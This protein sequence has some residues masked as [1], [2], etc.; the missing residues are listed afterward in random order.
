MIV[1]AMSGITSDSGSPGFG[2]SSVRVTEV[3]DPFACRSKVLMKC[4]PLSIEATEQMANATPEQAQEATKLL[5]GHPHPQPPRAVI[6]VLEH[7]PMPGM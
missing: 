6:E 2:M 7:L 1:D 3:P 5:G 4:S